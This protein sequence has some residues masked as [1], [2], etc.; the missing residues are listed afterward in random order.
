MKKEVMNKLDVL[1][2]KFRKEI[3][4]LFDNVSDSISMLYD[5]ATQDKKTGVYNH[6]F[7]QTIFKMEFEKAKRGYQRLSLFIADIDHFKKINDIYGH[8]EA[9]ELLKKLA[10]ILTQSTRESDIVARFG[11]EEFVILLPETSLDRAKEVTSRIRTAVKE[12]ELL[13][14]YS[15]TISGGLTEYVK[16]D[17]SQKMMKRVDKALYDAKKSGRDRLISI[18]LSSY[19]EFEEEKDA[20]IKVKPIKK[21]NK[22]Q[23]LTELKKCYI[24]KAE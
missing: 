23:I 11:G 3:D 12:D 13:K 20:P 21:L 5:A 10:E 17:T 8:I 19:G 1:D 24:V 6:N 18:G 2:P 7:F 9:D 14:K 15:L 4:K 16:G 22:K